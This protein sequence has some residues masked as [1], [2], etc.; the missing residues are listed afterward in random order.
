MEKRPTSAS[1]LTE[2]AQK[3]QTV[4]PVAHGAKKKKTL[5]VKIKE[6]FMTED[7]PDAKSNIVN[8]ILI[9]SAKNMVLDAI[10]SIT[11]SVA[12][13]VEMTLFGRVNP[14]SSRY[15]S[16]GYGMSNRTRYEDMYNGRSTTRTARTLSSSERSNFAFDNIVFEGI[17]VVDGI[18][19]TPRQQAQSVIDSMI[20]H[21]D[22]FGYAT[23]RD[24]Y[25]FAGVTS[26]DYTETSW[27]WKAF[28][29]PLR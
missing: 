23:V 22:I 9:P 16:S 25:D 18:E 24:M 13:T 5:G 2:K 8:D 10:R 17:E 7:L 6:T 4:K 20:E 12:D 14:R 3:S 11:N 21:I 1:V 15:W 27:G 28:L 29:T 19:K 26:R